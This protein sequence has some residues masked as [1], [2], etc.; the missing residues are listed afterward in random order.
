MF[1][2]ERGKKPSTF[3]MCYCLLIPLITLNTSAQGM[4][5][6]P[7]LS[8][9]HLSWLTFS[10]I[11]IF[12]AED[13]QMPLEGSICRMAEWGCSTMCLPLHSAQHHCTVPSTSMPE[14]G[15]HWRLVAAV[16]GKLT[17]H[18]KARCHHSAPKRALNLLPG[19]DKASSSW[20]LAALDQN[21]VPAKSSTSN[22]GAG[23]SGSWQAKPAGRRAGSAGVIVSRIPVSWDTAAYPGI[24]GSLHQ[25]KHISHILVR[26][27][28]RERR[29]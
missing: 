6:S 23:G 7:A 29:L 11:C 28:F 25:L 12:L 4:Y 10:L 9:D 16:L 1:L 8:S 15:C 14:P 5:C 19:W 17:G 26:S 3:E 27:R 13:A 2:K 18:T 24:K 21:Q 22:G 20:I